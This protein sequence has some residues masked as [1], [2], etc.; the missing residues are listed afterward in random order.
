[1][2]ARDI[3]VAARRSH[4]RVGWSYL[5]EKCGKRHVDLSGGYSLTSSDVVATCFHVVDPAR[6]IREGCLVAVDDQETVSPRS[7]AAFL[8]FLAHIHDSGS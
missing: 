4:L 7:F 3:C 5:C 1:L 6:E 8:Y 2:S